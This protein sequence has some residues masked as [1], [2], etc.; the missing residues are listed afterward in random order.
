[1]RAPAHL[2]VVH[3]ALPAVRESAAERRYTPVMPLRELVGKT[4]GF[5]ITAAA[6]VA[7][8]VLVLVGSHAYNDYLNGLL[9][10][11]LIALG[12]ATAGLGVFLIGG[13]FYDAKLRREEEAIHV[14]P[15]GAPPAPPPPWGMGDVGRPGGVVRVG[16]DAAARR[17]GGSPRVMSV[18]VSNVDGALLIAGLLAWT[19]LTLVFFAPTH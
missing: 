16:G 14:T 17:G 3:A 13:I 15:R 5:G 6:L 8:G 2:R 9:G 18:A 4:L 12:L 19:F 10:W 11:L 7:G 1:M